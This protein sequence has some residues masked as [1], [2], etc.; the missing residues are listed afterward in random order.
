MCRTGRGSHTA[1]G[2]GGEPLLYFGLDS[3]LGPE[4]DGRGSSRAPLSVIGRLAS[5]SSKTVVE[6]RP[7]SVPHPNDGVCPICSG[8]GG[9]Y[10]HSSLKS[11]IVMFD[12]ST[13]RHTPTTIATGSAQAGLAAIRASA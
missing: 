3:D 9:N 8:L 6:G 11:L 4:I 13:D 1:I 5:A 10:F 7:P 2:S 12:T